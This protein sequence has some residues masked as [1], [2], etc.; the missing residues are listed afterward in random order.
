MRLLSLCGSPHIQLGT[1][2]A[3]VNGSNK[4][5]KLSGALLKLARLAS[6]RTIFF[7]PL[8][9]ASLAPD[10]G[11]STKTAYAYHPLFSRRQCFITPLKPIVLFSP[12]PELA[13]SRRCIQPI[14][15]L[16]LLYAWLI[17]QTKYMRSTRWLNLTMV[18]FLPAFA[19]SK[20]QETSQGNGVCP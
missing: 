13:A 16:A 4:Q 8:V 12:L 19:A 7:A 2:S 17:G 6:C 3:P 9:P 14:R 15:Q 18:P 20:E 11:G 1:H 5:L 10:P